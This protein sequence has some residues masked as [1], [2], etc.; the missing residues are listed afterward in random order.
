MSMAQLDFLLDKIS[1]LINIDKEILVKID[2][3]NILIYSLVAQGRSVNAFKSFIFKIEEVFNFNEDLSD[4][5]IL[6]YIISDG[7]KFE[8]TL[9]NF[10]DFNEEL[11][12]ELFMSDDIQADNFV[13]KNSKL[14]INIIGGTPEGLN[15]D[16][17]AEK[18]KST[19]DIK[20]M[21]FKFDL[22][23]TSFE[24]IKKMSKIETQEN[25]ILYLNIVNNILSIGESGWD[26][27]ICDV[28][29]EDLS[30]TFP[31]KYFNSMN[32]VG[33]NKIAIY[34]FDTILFIDNKNTSL[35]IALEL[36]V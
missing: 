24:K 27:Q 6:K 22:E 10:L 16:I 31:K 12:C 33:E 7:K 5:Q 15:T 26:L 4:K 3:K 2:Y 25:D 18:I 36:S 9:R 11:N 35:I 34:V 30:I 23:K 19:I 28:S 17:D 8:T 20:N 1:D 13:L 21:D 14:K 32:F 29:H